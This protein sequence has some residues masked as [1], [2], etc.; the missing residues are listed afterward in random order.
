MPVQGSREEA[1]PGVAIAGRPAL[2]R[3]EWG[4]FRR[5][6]ILRRRRPSRLLAIPPLVLSRD[7]LLHL[8]EARGDADIQADAGGPDIP[9]G[10]V[11]AGDDDADFVEPAVGCSS[12]INNAP[13]SAVTACAA[14]IAQVTID[15]LLDRNYCDEIIDVYRALPEEPPFDRVGRL[16]VS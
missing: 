7:L 11:P 13:P 2:P 15:A 6:A 8:I 14:L 16:T 3:G 4:M 12:P 5:P 9:V 1:A 10:V